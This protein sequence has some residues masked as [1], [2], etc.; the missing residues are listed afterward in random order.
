MFI[1]EPIPLRRIDKRDRRNQP[2]VV[3]IGWDTSTR[4][5]RS[6]LEAQL[7]WRSSAEEPLEEAR[8]F[9]SA[10]LFPARAKFCYR[11]K[12]VSLWNHVLNYEGNQSRKSCGLRRLEINMRL[13]QQRQKQSSSRCCQDSNTDFCRGCPIRSRCR[14]WC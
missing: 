2:T 6:D 9:S 4:A 8:A 12:L 7:L 11:A 3:V 1:P 10:S 14:L 13:A 5:M